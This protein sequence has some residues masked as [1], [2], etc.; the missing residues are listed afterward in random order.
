MP[1]EICTVCGESYPGDDRD[2]LIAAALDHYTRVHPAWGLTKVAIENYY[3]A[4]DRL[5]D[6]TERLDSIG[7][8]E[9]HRITPDRVEDALGFLDRDAFAG[10]PEWAACYCMFFHREDPQQNG[11]NS[12]RENRA[13]MGDRLATGS[14]IAY[15][16]YVDGR[17]AGWCNASLR[18]AYPTQRTGVGDDEVGVIV[19][20]AIAPPY[21]KHGVSHRLLEAALDGYRALGIK[22]AQAHPV[23]DN[24]EDAPNYHGPLS[25]YLDTGFEIVERNERTALVEKLL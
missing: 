9:V 24:K 14:T 7:P 4:K 15:L 6:R 23:L 25:L 12:W 19:C 13:A 21:R 2:G 5:S 8:V 18:S 3:D 16:A 20:F 17:P 11:N 1:T 10:N 22:R